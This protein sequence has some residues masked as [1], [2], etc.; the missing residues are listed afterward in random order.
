MGR[1]GAPTTGES[2]QSEPVRRGGWFYSFEMPNPRV[3]AELTEDVR[4]GAPAASVDRALAAFVAEHYD[5][6]GLPGYLGQ[7][8]HQPSEYGFYGWA[9]RPS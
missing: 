4:T 1:L 9:P 2:E 3:A 6:L 7:V 8:T 5:R